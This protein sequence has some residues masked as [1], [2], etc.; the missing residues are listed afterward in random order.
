MLAD[1]DSNA[2]RCCVADY[3]AVFVGARSLCE[4]HSIPEDAQHLE[5]TARLDWQDLTRR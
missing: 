1:Q 2:R 3:T 5:R 4:G